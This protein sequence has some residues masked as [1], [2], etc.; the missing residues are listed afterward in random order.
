[1]FFDI[2]LTVVSKFLNSWTF[3]VPVEILPIDECKTGKLNFY[4]GHFVKYDC[5]KMKIMSTVHLKK[6][7]NEIQIFLMKFYYT[8]LQKS[9]KM[10]AVKV[11]CPHDLN[12]VYFVMAQLWWHYQTTDIKKFLKIK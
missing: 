5:K 11:V 10:S 2:K 12:N 3:Y 9:W 8:C 6:I 4:T 7:K 1:M